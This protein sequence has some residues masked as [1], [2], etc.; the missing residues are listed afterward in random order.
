MKYT[1]KILLCVLV[2]ITVVFLTGCVNNDEV[3]TDAK[4]F[5]EEYES[6]NGQEVKSN[7]TA[8]ELTISDDNPFVYATAEEI[9]EMI[10]N[11]ETF[12]VYFGFSTCPWCRSMVEVMIEVAEDIGLDTIYYVDVKDIR[13]VL[14]V[15]DGEVTTK[16]EGSDGYMDL[17]DRL[18]AVLADYTLTD[19]DDEEV[20]THMKRIYAP[21]VV[22][23]INGKS[24][25]MTTGT[26]EKL[27]NPYD[28]L[29]DEIK[30]ES[31]EM[32]ECTLNCVVEANSVCDRAC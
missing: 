12:A 26:S 2:M 13:N 4:K 23:V 21:N 28:E 3:T 8:R 18:D 5:K 6:V 7:T 9:V 19:E 14:E 17:L 11:E 15:V 31:Y 25:K 32:L 27:E 22:S 20:D 29:T 10:D 30:K 24:E 1:K 16:T